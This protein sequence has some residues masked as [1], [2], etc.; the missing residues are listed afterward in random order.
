M[1]ITQCVVKVLDGILSAKQAVGL[2]MG[3]DATEEL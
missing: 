2:L 3:R 1:P